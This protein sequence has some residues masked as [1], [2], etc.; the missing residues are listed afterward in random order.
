VRLPIEDSSSDIVF[1]GNVIEHL[2]QSPR[3]FLADLRRILRPGGYI[4]VDTINA[5]D[6]RRRI[7]FLCGVSNWPPIEYLYP[8]ETH[9]E[10][11]KEYTLAELKTVLQL[12]GFERERALAFE[13]FFTRPLRGSPLRYLRKSMRLMSE[14]ERRSIFTDRFQ[15]T[16]PAEYVRLSALGVVTLFP[17][18]RSDILVVGRKAH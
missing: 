11:H 9:H 15:P 1:V 5:V 18:L 8:M 10:H 4:V 17:S 6:L 14:M 13:A 7:K 3:E 16:N 12:S 2:P